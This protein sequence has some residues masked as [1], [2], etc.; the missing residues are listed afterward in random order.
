MSDQNILEL[1]Q[2]K[3]SQDR[4]RARQSSKKRQDGLLKKA[5]QFRKV[6]KIDVAMILF[7]PI[8]QQY[9]TYR[10]RDDESWPPSIMEI[11]KLSNSINYLPEDFEVKESNAN[12]INEDVYTGKRRRNKIPDISLKRKKAKTNSSDAEYRLKSSPQHHEKTELSHEM[13][14]LAPGL[15]VEGS[16]ELMK[17]TTP[18]S[19]MP[20]EEFECSSFGKKLDSPSHTNIVQPR[21]ISPLIFGSPTGK[22][23]NPSKHLPS[24]M[25]IPEGELEYSKRVSPHPILDVSLFRSSVDP[26]SSASHSTI[27][28]H[29]LE[30]LTSLSTKPPPMPRLPSFLRNRFLNTIT[31]LTQSPTYE[32][33]NFEEV[34]E[35]FKP[36]KKF[37]EFSP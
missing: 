37:E 5:E 24:A 15:S 23:D 26:N 28:E 30:D 6:A 25:I 2:F 16:N 32:F 12:P 11:K 4:I 14:P 8:S 1:R 36:D 33:P 17:D 29:E 20:A 10:S 21:D 22:L 19:I 7:D 18:T 34:F 3:A 27:Y 9:C 35:N 13:S 31:S